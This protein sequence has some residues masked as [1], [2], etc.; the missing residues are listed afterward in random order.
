[1]N[2]DYSDGNTNGFR[3]FMIGKENEETNDEFITF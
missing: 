2:K 1:V 3:W